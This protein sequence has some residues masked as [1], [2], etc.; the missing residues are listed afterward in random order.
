[1]KPHVKAPTE[2]Q[3]FE[4]AELRAGGFKWETVAGK[5]HRAVETVRRWPLRY[6][7]RWQAAIDRAELRR[8][9][10][11]DAEG[12]VILRSLARTSP[13]DNVRLNAAKTLSNIR[14]GLG[15]LA[16]QARK[17]TTPNQ[18]IDK[19]LVLA[20]LLERYTTH[21]LAELARC[22]TERLARGDGGVEGATPTSAA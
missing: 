8:A 6:A 5:V 2:E 17:Q 9:A 22:G 4:A 20:E 15:R 18:T 12:A 7:E 19:S 11:N 3:L 16:I 1:M 10:D 14:L 21:E 13:D